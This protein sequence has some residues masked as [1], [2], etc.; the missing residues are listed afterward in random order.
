MKAALKKKWIDAL[1][2]GNY[3]QGHS[4]LRNDDHYCCLGVLCD[5][6]GPTK[7][8]KDGREGD[9]YVWKHEN[10]NNYCVVP[11]MNE[12]DE[13][14]VDKQQVRLANMNDKENKSFEEIADY[15]EKNVQ[16]ED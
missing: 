8:D 16:E 3:K 9:T 1:R 10:K 2:S 11:Y 7:W 4:V 12:L 14:F 6:I 5:V 13:Y 15:I